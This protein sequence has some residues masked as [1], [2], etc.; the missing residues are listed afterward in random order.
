MKPLSSN[1]LHSWRCLLSWLPSLYHILLFLEFDWLRETVLFFLNWTACA[2][3]VKVLIGAIQIYFKLVSS[4]KLKD[5]SCAENR[6]FTDSYTGFRTIG[7]SNWPNF[8]FALLGCT[9]ILSCLRHDCHIRILHVF[10]VF[11]LSLTYFCVLKLR[12]RQSN[13]SI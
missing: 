13:G 3:L 6:G 11:L 4:Q 8:D 2:F 1:S 5:N 7:R 9:S 10:F 12:T